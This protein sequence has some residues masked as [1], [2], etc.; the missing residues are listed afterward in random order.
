M[1]KYIRNDLDFF[2]SFF[3]YRCDPIYLGIKNNI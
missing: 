1:D 3:W 2:W